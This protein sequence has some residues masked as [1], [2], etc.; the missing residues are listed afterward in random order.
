MFASSET[1]CCN[2]MLIYFFRVIKIRFSKHIFNA[3]LVRVEFLFDVE[4][5]IETHTFWVRFAESH[6]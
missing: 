3:T 2:L 5:F 1:Q 4:A 6:F